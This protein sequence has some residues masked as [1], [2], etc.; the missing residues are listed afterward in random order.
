MSAPVP[1]S[2]DQSRPQLSSGRGTSALQTTHAAQAAASDDDDDKL[3]QL[4][5]LAS[6]LL[7][8]PL[9]V[10]SLIT[11]DREVIIAAVSLP[12]PWASLGSIP[13]TQSLC[14]QV[15]HHDGALVLF[16]A[17]LDPTYREH[18]AVKD[19][20]VGAYAGYPLRCQ[21]QTVGAFCVIDTTRR[22]WSPRDLH[23]LED[24]TE[25]AAS[26]LVR[27]LR[28]APLVEILPD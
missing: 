12:E 18:P 1:P 21:G 4:V 17:R 24:L 5:R 23:L 13:L 27:R 22:H 25:N 20:G 15:V 3:Q 28:D 9:A 16:D 19:I 26:E 7:Q 14:A 10:V 6:R 11:A 8:V 2:G